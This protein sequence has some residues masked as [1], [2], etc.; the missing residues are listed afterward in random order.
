VEEAASE[1]MKYQIRRGD[2]LNQI[3]KEYYGNKDMVQTVCEWN[4]LDDG[5]KIYVGQTIEL[6]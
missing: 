3:C 1:P 2:T 5:D 4:G 6:P